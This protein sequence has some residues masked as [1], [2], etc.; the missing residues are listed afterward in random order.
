MK[1]SNYL[2]ENDP[3]ENIVFELTILT[4]QQGLQD[5]DLIPIYTCLD[6]NLIHLSPESD[7]QNIKKELLRGLYIK[8]LYSFLNANIQLMHVYP[9][10]L[11]KIRSY[12]LPKQFRILL[13]PRKDDEY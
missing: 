10:N 7:D 8:V 11:T 13:R 9:G 5:E 3:F 12:H 4:V 2:A 1:K 6:K